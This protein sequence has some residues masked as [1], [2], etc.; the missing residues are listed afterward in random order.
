LKFFRL[1]RNGGLVAVQG[2][3]RMKMWL[4]VPWPWE[5]IGDI[6]VEKFPFVIGRSRDA[7]C[8]LRWVFISRRHCQ[9]V[10]ADGKILLQDLESCNGTFVNGRRI[11]EPTPV[12]HGDEISLGPLSLRVF[13]QRTPDTNPSLCLEP[14]QESLKL[15]TDDPFDPTACAEG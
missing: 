13:V 11:C 6:A 8:S 4:Q 7:H 14:T 10:W 12:D 3:R 5:G 9:F 2:K 1:S 15:M